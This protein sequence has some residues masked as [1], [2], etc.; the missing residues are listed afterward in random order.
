MK[1]FSKIYLIGWLFAAVIC[2]ADEAAVIP[3]DKKAGRFIDA[4]VHF[5]CCK[6]GDL[7]KAVV[8]MKSN[9]VQRI[10]NYPLAQ[11]RPKNEDE[12]KQ[13]LANYAKYKGIIGRACVIFPEE[14]KSVEEA[15]KILTKEKQDGAVV[16]GEH[17]GASSKLKEE[18]VFDA[19][20]CMVLFEACDKVGLPLMFHMDRNKNLDEKGL[21]RLEH[22]LKTFPNLI[23]I[24]HSDW[25]R[26]L[27]DGTCGRLLKTY[28]NLYA[29]I[30]CTTGR[31][32][33]GKDKKLAKEFFISNADKLLFGTDS[34]WWSLNAKP[35]GGEFAL[36]NELA[37]P[38]D[39]EDK[40]CRG[41]AE[42]LFWVGKTESSKTAG[43]QVE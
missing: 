16:F 10:I 24:A 11:S 20:Q 14:V 17:Y 3:P 39:F 23:L 1:R 38:K 35:S 6:A 7:D 18:N 43:E 5:T 8:W 4:H 34:G 31:S 19:P 41:N 32:I 2:L 29:D 25:W 12:R 9:N 30:S 27:Q 36:I 40:I 26:N 13:M 28:P 42:K 22:V 21:P 15:V 33:I 37:L